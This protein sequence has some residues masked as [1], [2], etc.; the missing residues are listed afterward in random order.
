[1]SR[2][3]KYK[4]REA[5]E[6]GVAARPTY[7]NLFKQMHSPHAMAHFRRSL[8]K[9]RIISVVP[10]AQASFSRTERKPFY[11][12]F[13]QEEEILHPI[14]ERI[15]RGPDIIR[16]ELQK[17]YATAII[18][19]ILQNSGYQ[20]KY[21]GTAYTFPDMEIVH[22]DIYQ[23]NP[24]SLEAREANERLRSSPDLWV[25]PPANI[26]LPESE[27][28]FVEVTY[29]PHPKVNTLKLNLDAF[30]RYWAERS[31]LVVVFGDK[32]KTYRVA[33]GR[34]IRF[35]PAPNQD[36][37]NFRRC[38]DITEAFPPVSRTQLMQYQE[39]TLASFLK[40]LIEQ[41]K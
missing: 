20:A 9:E 25:N 11:S 27:P 31:F 40:Y 2:N 37:I 4:L 26:P 15:K 22:Q 36:A 1:M 13:S 23:D 3:Q 16:S 41:E 21:H 39:I 6:Q 32:K 12:A 10:E 14:I 18:A 35:E 29:R 33:D 7:L 5:V 8:L 28:F 24:E 34:H 19:S 30:L 17:M 38:M